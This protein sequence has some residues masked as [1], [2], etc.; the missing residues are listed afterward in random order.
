VRT[1]RRALLL[2]SG[3]ALGACRAGDLGGNVAA[4]LVGG[5]GGGA[6]AAD[7]AR[8]AVTSL[9]DFHQQ[10]SIRFSPEQ[11]Y[12]LGRA[13]AANVLAR[14]GLDPDERRQEYVRKVGATLVTLSDHVRGTYGGYH[15]AVLADPKP[16]GVS[17]PGGF[18]FVTRGAVDLCRSEDELAG[19]LAHEIAHVHAKHGEAIIRRGREFQNEMQRL[20]VVVRVAA[21]A[22][23]QGG[24]ATA[25]VAALF[26]E[27][28]ESYVETLGS[29]GYGRD[30]EFQADLDGS[31]ILYD[32]GY[33]ATGI[34][35]YLKVHPDRPTTAWSTHGDPGSRGTALQPF[36][37]GYGGSFD[38]G[39]GRNARLERWKAL[40]AA[41]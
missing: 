33:D 4:N 18:V 23:G 26:R 17:G 41:P 28:V 5:A 12:Y 22:S 8:A 3:L 15:F 21:A 40:K 25:Q 27:S 36:L 1:P 37:G 39:V 6:V 10:V 31:R 24:Q 19:I 13:V 14:H 20:G 16:N 7:I 35:D 30:F 9:S 32:V 11:E 38:G 34:A 29:T 2:V